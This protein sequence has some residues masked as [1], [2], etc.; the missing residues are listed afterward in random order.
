MEQDMLK[1]SA[2]P[3][4]TKELCGVCGINQAVGKVTHYT[5]TLHYCKSEDCKKKA[6]ETAE[7]WGRY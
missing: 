3:S 5:V 6:E 2:V 1:H 4:N 7:L